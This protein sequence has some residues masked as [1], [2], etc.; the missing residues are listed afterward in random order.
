[1]VAVILDFHITQRNKWISKVA[2]QP[3]LLSN[4]SVDSEHREC[5]VLKLS[6]SGGHFG[7]RIDE[8]IRNISTIQ[9]HMWFLIRRILKFL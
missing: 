2:F 7:F 4:G 3:S 8:K 5:H 1:M 9:S 6:T